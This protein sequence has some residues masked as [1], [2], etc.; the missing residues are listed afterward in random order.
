MSKPKFNSFW[1]LQLISIQ[2][3]NYKYTS[4]KSNPHKTQLHNNDQQC[5]L[6]NCNNNFHFSMTL[7]TLGDQGKV[8]GRIISVW[9]KSKHTYRFIFPVANSIYKSWAKDA[10]VHITKQCKHYWNVAMRWY[11]RKIQ[12]DKIGKQVMIN[13]KWARDLNKLRYI[14]AFGIDT[15]DIAIQLITQEIFSFSAGSFSKT[16]CFVLA[17]LLEIQYLCTWRWLSTGQ[18]WKS[19]NLAHS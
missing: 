18:T 4:G 16:W 8:W 13:K 3:T 15:F 12:I 1:E 10:P 7:K 14:E 6:E 9:R 2:T 17:V 11:E 19:W 5:T